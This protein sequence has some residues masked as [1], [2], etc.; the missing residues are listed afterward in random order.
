MKKIP[1]F[2]LFGL[3]IITSCKTKQSK[4]ETKDKYENSK[5][6]I[7]EVEKKSPERFLSVTGKDKHNIIGQTVVKGTITN[8]ATVV[9]YKDVII[10]ISFFSKTG[11]L[12]EEDEEVIYETLKPGTSNNFKSKYFAPKGTDN[13]TMKI[14]TAGVEN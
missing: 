12:L 2:L 13:I 9:A 6:T 14:K 3:I 1:L 4:N 8:K 5:L 7:E 10:L 11:A